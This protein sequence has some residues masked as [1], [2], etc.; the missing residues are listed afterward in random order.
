MCFGGGEFKVPANEGEPENGKP[1]ATANQPAL[2]M[3]AT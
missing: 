1:A 3:S 2:V